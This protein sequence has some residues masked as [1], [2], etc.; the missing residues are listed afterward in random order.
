MTYEEIKEYAL[1]Y[2]NAMVDAGYLE[3]PVSGYYRY[4]NEGNNKNT[5]IAGKRWLSAIRAKSKYE[6]DNI[7][8]VWAPWS[9]D[10]PTGDWGWHS[11]NNEPIPRL[12]EVITFL[13]N[14]YEL[15]VSGLGDDYIE[16]DDIVL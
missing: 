2:K 16:L 10:N 14:A 12:E 11:L 5:D 13:I 4:S 1:Q 6:P 3:D 7:I 15:N 8:E 9:L